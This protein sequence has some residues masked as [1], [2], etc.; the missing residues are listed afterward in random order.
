MAT[1]DFD[2]LRGRLKLTGRPANLC[3]G[4]PLEFIK[5]LT[6]LLSVEFP[7]NMDLKLIVVGHQTPS[8]DDADKMWAQTDTNG[9]PLGWFKKIKGQWRKFYT[10]V[11]G[12]VRWVIGNSATPPDGWQTIDESTPGLSPGLVSKIKSQYVSNSTGGYSYYAV[13]YIGY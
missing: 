12:E 4:N 8:P 5:L 1:T 10:V 11:P 3:W 9:N 6:K 13:R 2:T 7:V